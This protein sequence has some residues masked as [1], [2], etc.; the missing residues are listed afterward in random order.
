M[1]R[2]KR[3]SGN[4]RTSNVALVHVLSRLPTRY[5][6]RCLALS[7]H[8]RRLVG[9]LDFWLQL[10][11]LHRRRLV[12]AMP[13]IAYM[14][15]TSMLPAGPLFYEF[16]VAAGGSDD[17]D[18]MRL[19]RPLIDREAK[20]SSRQRYAGTCN[21][22][23]VLAADSFYSSTTVVLFNPAITGSEV[24]VGISDNDRGQHGWFGS[25]VSGFGYGPTCL[26]HK[27]LLAKL[28]DRYVDDDKQVY[29]ATELLAYTFG[30]ATT[31]PDDQQPR[32]RTVMSSGRSSIKISAT[33]VYLDGKIYLLADH[34]RVLAF[35]VDKETVTG[36]ELP[37]DRVPDERSRHA[38]SELMEMSDRLCVATAAGEGSIAL[39]LLIT[40]G[41]QKWEQ[42]CVLPRYAD[43]KLAGAWDCGGVLLLL[44]EGL[45]KKTEPDVILYDTRAT[46][47]KASEPLRLHVP[48]VVAE[49]EQRRSTA[50]V[51]CWGYRPTLVSPGIIIGRGGAPP[52]QRRDGVVAAL[53]PVLQRDVKA[54]RER[55]LDTVCFMDFLHHIMRQLPGKLNE[56]VGEWRQCRLIRSLEFRSLHC[57]LA[58]PLP[59]PHI[60]YLATAPIKRMPGQDEPSS[61]FLGFHVAGDGLGGGTTTSMRSGGPKSF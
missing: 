56:V 23:V 22:V 30:G 45:T 42:R 55:T 27:L 38:K 3:N 46:K 26:R 32:C 24:V 15:T 16:H 12:P 8:H 2:K 39:W 49:S 53:N 4:N 13:R 50:H 48:R 47:K 17:D 35:D 31:T 5:A 19:R 43:D 25:R 41:D 40:A 58:P 51:F 52:R 60:A 9:S 10:Q 1:A 11:L 14:A 37:G 29:H 20:V 44:F 28:G 33:S 61:A 34:S 54:G 59:H 6:V 18:L 57:R 7:R 36:I 21:G